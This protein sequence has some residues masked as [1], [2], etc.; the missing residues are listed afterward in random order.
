MIQI[1]DKML[2]F[3]DKL[4]DGSEQELLALAG[5]IDD[6]LQLQNLLPTTTRVLKQLGARG[7]KALLEARLQAPAVKQA[8]QEANAALQAELN[9]NFVIDKEAALAQLLEALEKGAVDPTPT[10]HVA[11]LKV[12][13]ID[14]TSWT[15]FQKGFF[16]KA[17]VKSTLLQTSLDGERTSVLPCG[18][19]SVLSVD[20]EKAVEALRQELLLLSNSVGVVVKGFLA[21]PSTIELVRL[22]KPGE[23]AD[24]P[25]VVDLSGH[26]PGKRIWAAFCFVHGFIAKAFTVENMRELGVSGAVLEGSAGVEIT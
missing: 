3:T 1:E 21:K 7:F 12:E 10:L 25:V 16:D 13:Q 22:A 15:E 9:A 8:L 14:T 26:Q 20:K 11:Q 18:F 5:E 24:V 6:L 19:L 23:V 2:E 17:V 4:T